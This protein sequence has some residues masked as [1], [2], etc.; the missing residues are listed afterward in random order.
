M[1]AGIYLSSKSVSRN[2]APC[3]LSLFLQ[4]GFLPDSRA[5]ACLDL[6]PSLNEVEVLLVERCQSNGWSNSVWGESCSIFYVDCHFRSLSEVKMLQ[7]PESS[8]WAKRAPAE[9][10]SDWNSS[11]T[12]HRPVV[13]VFR[14]RRSAAPRKKSDKWKD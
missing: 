5:T 11:A 13:K 3:T 6:G 10:Y 8:S 12:N 7:I 4:A 14:R 2:L 1:R 9:T